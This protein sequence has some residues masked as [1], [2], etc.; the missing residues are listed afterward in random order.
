MEICKPNQGCQACGLGSG[1]TQHR[2]QKDANTN[3]K[4]TNLWSQGGE[5]VEI[6]TRSAKGITQGTD[7]GEQ[8][9]ISNPKGQNK[10]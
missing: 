2:E 1:N 4:L 6:E 9:N 3:D 7:T 10:R 5:R 8:V